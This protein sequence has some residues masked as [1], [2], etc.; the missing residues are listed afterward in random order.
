MDDDVDGCMWYINSISTRTTVDQRNCSIVV[1][2]FDGDD[3]PVVGVM[4]DGC[5]DVDTQFFL[6]YMK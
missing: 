1:E 4:T 2:G 6:D 3:K 5:V